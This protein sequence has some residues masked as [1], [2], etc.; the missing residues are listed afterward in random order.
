MSPARHRLIPVGATEPTKA[1]S[2]GI[3]VDLDASTRLIFTMGQIAIDDD[4]NV[5]SDDIAEQARYVFEQIEAILHAGGATMHDIVK[6]QIFL[7]DMSDFPV[8]SSIRNEFLDAIRPASAVYE[9]GALVRPTCRV[10]V[11]VMAIAANG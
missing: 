3:A 10:E 7:I 11:D 6:V 4:G 2:H 5:I 1:Y 9:V 8:V